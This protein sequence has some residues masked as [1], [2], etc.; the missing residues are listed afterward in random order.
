MDRMDPADPMDRMDPADPMD[1]MDP[2]DP[3][4][5][6]DP[7]DPLDLLDP[8]PRTRPAFPSAC[9]AASGMPTAVAPPHLRRQQATA[10]VAVA[11]ASPQRQFGPG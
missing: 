4:D 10:K 7:L 11:G 5:R 6:I 1:R 3:M 9:L 2:A 8:M